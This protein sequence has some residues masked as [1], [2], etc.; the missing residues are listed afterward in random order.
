MGGVG[1]GHTAPVVVFS[2]LHNLLIVMTGWRGGERILG[3]HRC[4][5][6]GFGF[7]GALLGDEATVKGTL[8]GGGAHSLSVLHGLGL[9]RDR[10]EDKKKTGFHTEQITVRTEKCEPKNSGTI[11]EGC[12]IL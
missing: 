9:G 2:C 11:Q 1:I 7:F 6:R 3:I 4:H 5:V 12:L 8:P 10:K